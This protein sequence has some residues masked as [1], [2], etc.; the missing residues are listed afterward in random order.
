M[1]IRLCPE[2]DNLPG[3]LTIEQI[4]EQWVWWN[5]DCTIIV[6]ED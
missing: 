1:I 3:I 4:R 6:D 2:H 5:C